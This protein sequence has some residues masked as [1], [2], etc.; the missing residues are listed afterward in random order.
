MFSEQLMTGDADSDANEEIKLTV[1][2]TLQSQQKGGVELNKALRGSTIMSK[3][4]ETA[5][6]RAGL[7]LESGSKGQNNNRSPLVKACL[8]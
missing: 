8:N 3:L 2:N 6:S 4:N 7:T 5:G 1:T